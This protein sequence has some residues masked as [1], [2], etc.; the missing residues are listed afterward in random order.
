MPLP[1]SF[2]RL[3][4]KALE[5]DSARND[6]TSRLTVS[7]S[8]RSQAAIIAKDNGVVC[9]IEIARFVFSCLDRSNEFKIHKHDGD[10]FTYREKIATINGKTRAILGAERMAL[11]FLCL[12]SGTATAT[13]RLVDKVRGYP[14]TILS[15]RKTTPTLRKLEEYAVCIGGGSHHRVSLADWVLIK[16]N[17]LRASGCVKGKTVN[18]ARIARIMK[19]IR[20]ATSTTIEVEVEN[21]SEFIHVANNLPDIIMLDNFPIENL[22]AAVRLRNKKYPGIKLE[23]SGGVNEQSVK[24]IAATGVDFISVGSI[25]HSPRAIDFSLEF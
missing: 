4:R 25:T 14:V 6:I 17:H 12:L 8:S 16:D 11:N 21:L 20:R 10:R 1:N 19:K 24:A 7:A 3:A 18:P 2:K 15:T 9:G 23:A 13:R 5:E 22:I